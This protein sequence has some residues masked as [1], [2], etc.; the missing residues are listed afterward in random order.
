MNKKYV[1]DTLR[2]WDAFPDERKQGEAAVVLEAGIR[3]SVEAMDDDARGQFVEIARRQYE[4]QDATRASVTS[5]A[6]TLLLFVGVISTGATVVA[7]SLQTAQP[8]ILIAILIDGAALLYACLAV[9]F[10]AVRAQEVATW[11]GPAIYAKQGTSAQALKATDA[12][13]HAVAWEQNKPGIQHLVGYLLNAQRWARRA[14][15]LVVILAVLSVAAA[16][17]KPPA[18]PTPGS[19]PAA[20]AAPTQTPVATPAPTVVPTGTPVASQAPTAAP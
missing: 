1:V 19:V 10:L 9:A 17:T 4:E 8:L 18:P 14:I 11:T 5:R 16:A 20:T 13:E 7:A 2:F 3:A 6:S 12:V 15:I